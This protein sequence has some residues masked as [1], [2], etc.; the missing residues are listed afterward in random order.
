MR[1]HWKLK[2]NIVRI[3]KSIGQDS[4]EAGKLASWPNWVKIEV[5]LCEVPCIIPYAEF[6]VGSISGLIQNPPLFG[7]Y[8]K[9]FTSYVIFV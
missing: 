4:I 1:N 6:S 8:F 9:F 7:Q 5:S 2:T 3:I